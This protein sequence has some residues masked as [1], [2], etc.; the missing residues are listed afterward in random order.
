[1][2]IQQQDLSKA[3]PVELPDRIQVGPVVAPGHTL[4]TVTDRI[5]N[6]VLRRKIGLGWLFGLLIAFGVTQLLA[7]SAAWL[8]IKGVG[9]WGINIPIGWGFAIV[10]F[11]W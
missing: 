4:A 9:I 3:Q 6:V 2:E 1:M 5:A 10:N 7:I 11:V 8:F